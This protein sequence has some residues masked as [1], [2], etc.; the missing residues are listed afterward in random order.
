MIDGTSVSWKNTTRKTM[1][2]TRARGNRIAYAPRTAAIDPDAPTSGTSE[3][4]S[5]AT[6]ASAAM[7]PPA[8]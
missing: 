5:I 1:V 2:R 3:L 4:G 7:I 6:W 8:R